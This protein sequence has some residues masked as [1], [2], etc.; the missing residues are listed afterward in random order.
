GHPRARPHP[1]AGGGMS[2]PAVARSSPNA[3]RAA[4]VG[5]AVLLTA[6]AVTTAVTAVTR[7]ADGAWMRP[8]LWALAI[9]PLAVVLLLPSVRRRGDRLAARLLHGDD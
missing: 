6:L 4:I 7:A 1:A 2:V 9:A 3:L 5:G 8:P